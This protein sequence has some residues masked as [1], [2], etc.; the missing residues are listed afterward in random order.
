MIKEIE[1][2]LKKYLPKGNS[3]VKKAMRYSVLSSGKRIRPILAIESAKICGGNIKEIMPV[4]CALEFIHTYSLIHDDLPA[5]DNDNFRRGKPTCHKVF[6]EANAILAGDGLLTLAFNIIAR[7]A[8]PKI[9]VNIIR[10]LSDAAGVDGMV[11]GQAMDLE[12]QKNK[13]DKNIL[14]NINFLKTA[15]LLEASAKIG[16]LAACAA[17]DKVKALGKFGR[18]LGVSFQMVDDH[19]D[20]ESN[21]RGGAGY[22]IEKAKKEL[23]PFGK[24]ADDLK[25]LADRLLKRKK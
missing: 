22:F 18:D 11:S 25:K 13:K 7:Y 5:M 12:F 2:N 17:P 19:L 8:E 4:A 3:T 10:E 6:G 9:A 14:K 15:K 1:K 23:A 20:G 24:K 21:S 16:A